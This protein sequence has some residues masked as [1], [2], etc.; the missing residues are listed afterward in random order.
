VEGA[1]EAARER[2]PRV[3]IS[4]EWLTVPGGSEQVVEAML[5]VFP[6]AE[7]FTSVHDPAA[8]GPPIADRP[9]HTSLL[10]R[11][12]RATRIYPRL[13]PLMD[14][15]FRSFDLGGFDLILSSNHA[16]AKNV[17][18]PES[19]LHVCYCHTPMRYA[20]D[21]SFLHDEALGRVARL[22]APPL[23]A[24]LRHR[25][26][27]GAQRPDGFMANSHFVADRIRR[28]Y[29]RESEV[30]HPPVN[31]APMLAR[32]R[33]TPG[34]Y[35]FL[36]RLVPYK[37]ADLAV[38]ACARLGRPLKV[39]GEGRGAAAAR[40][41]AG[42]TVEFLGR[43]S[44]EALTETLA[45]AKALIFPA[46]EDFGIVPVEAQAAGVPVIAYRGGGARD[47]VVE[48]DTGVFHDAQTPESLAAAILEF[49]DLTFDEQAIRDNARRFAPERFDKEI[50]ALILD[51]A[52][53][54]WN[55]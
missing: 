28:F 50:A 16:C 18:T 17:R 29:G 9:V 3:A 23:L 27:V 4:H 47:S 13:L 25:D 37:R 26:R 2:F 55:G 51:Q 7:I 36:S 42:P 21:P 49:E 5:E 20:W 6:D 54:R 1:I 43:L 31:V 34:H 14:A 35:L 53:V 46:E 32:P 45:G 39:V 41:V 44:D 24:Y 30:L 8:F 15:A 52:A 11:V 22:V 38:A 12:P 10:D 19:A 40:A 48:G 33:R